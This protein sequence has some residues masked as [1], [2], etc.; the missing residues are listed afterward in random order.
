M[1]QSNGRR[2]RNMLTFEKQLAIHN[3]LSAN[4]TRLANEPVTRDDLA[5]QISQHVGFD[6][7]MSNLRTIASARRRNLRDIIR[8]VPTS[9]EHIRNIKLTRQ[10]LFMA[11][12]ALAADYVDL[13]REFDRDVPE[14]ITEYLD[15]ISEQLAAVG[16]EDEETDD[17]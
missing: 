4:W 16:D 15:R 3:W 11:M 9:A 10:G 5:A 17:E 8:R 12:D 6:V 7:S 2:R 1:P 13:C 14:A